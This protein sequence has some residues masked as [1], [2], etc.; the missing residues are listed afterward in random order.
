MTETERLT[1][2]VVLR[3]HSAASIPSI[4]KGTTELIPPVLVWLYNA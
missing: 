4:F 3:A 1:D 2:I